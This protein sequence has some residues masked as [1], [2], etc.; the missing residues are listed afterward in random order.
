MCAAPATSPR[1]S[2]CSGLTSGDSLQCAARLRR[3]RSIC[4]AWRSLSPP[5]KQLRHTALLPPTAVSDRMFNR[6]LAAE[7]QVA[8][9]AAINSPSPDWRAVAELLR[10]AMQAGRV[11]RMAKAE[12]S[13]ELPDY[14]V[15]RVKLLHRS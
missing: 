1:G 5:K 13:G 12:W 9:D 6:S 10:A 7:A 3:R 8:Y 15:D 11:K 4:A 14:N 2:T